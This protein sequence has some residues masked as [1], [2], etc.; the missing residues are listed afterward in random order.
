MKDWDLLVRWEKVVRNFPSNPT[1]L[2]LSSRVPKVSK[3]PLVSLAS[4]VLQ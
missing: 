3:A 2:S 4:L 1:P